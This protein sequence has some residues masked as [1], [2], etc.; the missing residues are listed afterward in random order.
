MSVQ[1]S[2][3]DTGPFL[4]RQPGVGNAGLLSVVPP[5][6]ALRRTVFHFDN[7]LQKE[8]LRGADPTEIRTLTVSLLLN[9][10]LRIP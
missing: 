10:F 4:C 5:G 9:P 1:V 6:P 3:R 8:C 2:L 7:F